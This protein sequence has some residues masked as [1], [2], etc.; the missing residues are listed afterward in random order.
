MLLPPRFRSEPSGVSWFPSD[1]RPL[2]EDEVL[3]RLKLHDGLHRN[4][5]AWLQLFVIS[6]LTVWF[7]PMIASRCPA[8]GRYGIELMSAM[9]DGSQDHL[10]SM[11]VVS[12][13]ISMD[14]L[15]ARVL[16]RLACHS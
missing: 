2:V 3:R 9:L 10:I 13:R 15:Q 5:K 16:L 7:N 8:D 6:F 12:S 14:G 1:L 11:W 4:A